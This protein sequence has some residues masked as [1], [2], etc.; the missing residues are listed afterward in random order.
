MTAPVPT[1]AEP[2]YPGVAGIVSELGA[3]ADDTGRF[4]RATATALDERETFPVDA[5]RWLD[6]LAVPAHYV[7]ARYG[8]AWRDHDELVHLVRA[9]SRRDLTV[10]V[11]HA[12][13]FL[14]AASVWVGGDP[15]QCRRLAGRVLAGAPVAWGLT[16]PGHGSDLMATEMTAEPTPE[17]FRLTG[18][19]RPVNNATRS[20]LVCVLARTGAQR[21][22]RGLSVLLVDKRGLPDGSF[23]CL[24]KVRTHGIRGADISGIDLVAAPVGPEALIGRRG[25]GLE[26]VLRALQLTRVVCTGLSLGAADHALRLTWDFVTRRRLYEHLLVDMPHVRRTLGELCARAFLVES[27]SILAARLTHTATGEMPV[28]SA[29]VKAFVPTVVDELVAGCA[30]LLGAR[31]FMT[32]VYAHGAFAKLERDHRIVGIFDGNTAVNRSAVVN[33]FPV[34]VQAWRA[35]TVE[36][37][38]LR[39]AATLRPGL[40]EIRE[41][42]LTSRTGCSVVQSLPAAVAELDEP[43]RPLGTALLRLADQLHQEM[44]RQRQRVYGH[45]AE[46]FELVERYEWCFAGA[47][48]I[49]LWLANRASRA[50]QRDVAGDWWHEA[51]WLRAALTLAL[52]RLGHRPP[53]PAGAV[54]D[55]VAGAVRDAGLPTLLSVADVEGE[56]A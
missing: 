12:K 18:R 40:G 34:L 3:F 41:L 13:T 1:R 8:G 7:P 9:M 31:A 50:P 14:G 55:E 27:A 10:S 25:T 21:D 36:S 2:L 4:S 23:R 6:S 19:K 42:V 32:N 15:E 44:A 52:S 47:A 35:G 33:H 20:E 48:A 37:Q 11:A 51:R 45:S 43:L 22:P 29:L 30:E 39:T 46:A 49:Q 53:A 54:F 24:P 26:T 16:E 17:G 5:C 56:L 38:A 28:V